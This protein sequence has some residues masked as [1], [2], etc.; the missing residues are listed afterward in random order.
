MILIVASALLWFF[1]IGFVLE[2]RGS[3]DE[4]DVAMAVLVAPIVFPFM[5]GTIFCSWLKG[6]K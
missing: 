6:K 3:N 4:S 1:A 5:L 2:Y